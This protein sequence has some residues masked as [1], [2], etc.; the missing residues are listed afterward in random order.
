[1]ARPRI[2]IRDVAARAGVSRQTISRVINGSE[3]VSPDTE[4]RVHAAIAELGYQPNAIA[5][6]MARGRTQI[7]ACISPNLTD[8]TFASV[9]N[10]A[11]AAVRAHGFFLMSSSAPDAE[12]FTSLVDELI[13][14]GHTEGL[15][16][17]N[18]FADERHEHLP[19]DFP[20]VLVG[21]RP[22]A[23][24]TNSVALDDVAAGAM[25]T[26][27]LLALGHRRIATVTGPLAEDCSQDRLA[28][29]ERAL[30]H[31]SL[32]VDP[33]LVLEG[34]WSARAGYQALLQ[35]AEY[36]ELPTALFAQNDQMAVGALRAARDLGLAVPDGLSIVGVDDIPLAA[37]LDPPLTTVWQDFTLIGREAARLLIR[38]M[39]Q[40]THTPEHVL[41]APQLLVRRSTQGAAH[42][43]G[44]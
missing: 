42:A 28:G 4:A 39:E 44:V 13:G 3:L 18:P 10:G 35:L 5:R 15:L 24:Q 41:L 19:P 21:A 43:L 22:R 11:E 1:M 36:D 7:L 14:S 38:A 16:V 31:H 25:A 17:V 34:D 40:P 37:H 23:G 27:H 9:I 32:A 2:T 8:H 33:G 29:Y 26:E 20:T 6:S 30:A 12:T